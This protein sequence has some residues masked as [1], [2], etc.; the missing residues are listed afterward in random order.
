MQ[1]QKAESPPKY[2]KNAESYKSGLACG[3]YDVEPE[4]KAC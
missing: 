2:S 4:A 3:L 1:N